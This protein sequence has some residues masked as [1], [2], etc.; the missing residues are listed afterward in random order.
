M[1][2]SPLPRI[3]ATGPAERKLATV[4]GVQSLSRSSR[5]RARKPAR[6]K[7]QPPRAVSATSPIRSTGRGV[8]GVDDIL[9]VDEGNCTVLYCTVLYSFSPRGVSIKQISHDNESKYSLSIHLLSDLSMNYEGDCFILSFFVLLLQL[10]NPKVGSQW[11]SIVNTF[12]AG[13]G[14]DPFS[15]SKRPKPL[16]LAKRAETEL[17]AT[18][19]NVRRLVSSCEKKCHLFL[20]TCW[21]GRC[22][23]VVYNSSI[24][25]K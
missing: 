25:F 15:T 8:C 22:H 16:D 4:H 7:L 24:I 19:R 1:L 9:P 23:F 21:F 11:I 10:Q 5:W 14:H 6:E 18:F 2:S 17:F 13:N 3:A 20:L 12:F